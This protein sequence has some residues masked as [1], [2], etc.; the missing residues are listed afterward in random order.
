MLAVKEHFMIAID[1]E[2]LAASGIS[3]A[4]QTVEGNNKR[5]GIKIFD[6][7]TQ[8]L[9]Q[10]IPHPKIQE[11]EQ[12]NTEFYDRPKW[13]VSVDS[14]AD[15]KKFIIWFSQ[16]V[17][18]WSLDDGV[19]KLKDVNLGSRVSTDTRLSLNKNVILVQNS[20]PSR[21]SHFGLINLTEFLLYDI[22]FAELCYFETFHKMY[23]H[24]DSNVATAG[25]PVYAQYLTDDM[26]ILMHSSVNGGEITV[27]R[28]NL[29]AKR[30]ISLQATELVEKRRDEELRK[31]IREAEKK[32]QDDER[33]KKREEQ[34]LSRFVV[35]KL[36]S[37]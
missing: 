30:I 11:P 19:K 29:D 31:L 7:K 10:M 4:K 18:Y 37:C 22:E 8:T 1:I 14:N 21:D 33:M 2:S 26:A 24:P 35:L 27:C 6:L 16:H 3:T 9:V 17:Q 13:A 12:L 5:M 15:S 34:R 20:T 36:P 28:F 25:G 32:R 23:E